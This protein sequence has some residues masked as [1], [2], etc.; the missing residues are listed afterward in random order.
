MIFLVLCLLYDL[1]FVLSMSLVP[2]ISSSEWGVELLGGHWTELLGVVLFGLIPS[3]IYGVLMVLS[4][5][6]RIGRLSTICRSLGLSLIPWGIGMMVML[7]SASLLTWEEL[8][9][10]LSILP[11][12]V[13]AGVVCGYYVSCFPK[14]IAAD[15]YGQSET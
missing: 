11:P 14:R 3:S 4:G 12:F 15:W 5:N 6:H 10:A 8:Q 7:C 2:G 13:I 1:S 9:D